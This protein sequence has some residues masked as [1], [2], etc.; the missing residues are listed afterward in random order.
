M[1]VLDPVDLAI[2]T[3]KNCLGKINVIFLF[4]KIDFLGINS[5]LLKFLFT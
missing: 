1:L 2:D 3:G 5:I 4:V